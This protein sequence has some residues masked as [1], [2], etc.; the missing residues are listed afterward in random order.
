MRIQ[1]KI[2]GATVLSLAFAIPASAGVKADI[3]KN[4]DGALSV[5]EFVM[6]SA[7][8]DFKQ[9]D[10]NKDEVFSTE[11]WIGKGGGKF[12]EVAL[13]KFDADKDGKL[14]TPEVVE[15]YLWTFGNRDK[16]RDDQLTGDEIPKAM[17]SG[18][19]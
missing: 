1:T 8:R 18:K 13:K 16:N 2:F 15:V 19:S 4:G 10:A 6:F 3:D 17:L 14:T 11:E 12:R 5:E 9:R 7:K